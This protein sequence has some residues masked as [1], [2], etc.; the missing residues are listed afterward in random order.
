MITN[1]HT[2]T[3][4]L[5]VILPFLN[6][7]EEVYNTVCSI[8]KTSINV[9]IILINDASTDKYDYINVAKMFDCQ[10]IVHAKRK[11]VAASRDEGVLLCQTDYFLLLDAHMR[12]YQNNWVE[13]IVN[14]LSTNA[15]ILLCCQTKALSINK[16]GQIVLD[17]ERP[18]S[19]GSYIDL[20]NQTFLFEPKWIFSDSHLTYSSPNCIDIPCVLGAGYATSKQY[21]LYLK[22]LEELEQYGND[23][24]YI[25]IKVWLDGGRCVLLKN[26]TIGHI[27]RNSPPYPINQLYRIYNRLLLSELLLPVTLLKKVRSTLKYTYNSH[28]YAHAVWLISENK[29]IVELRKYYKKKFKHNFVYFESINNQH[30]S[31]VNQ[32]KNIDNLLKLIAYRIITQFHTVTDMGLIK[33]QIGLI[34]FLFHYAQYDSNQMIK[35]LALIHLDNLCEKIDGRLSTNFHSGLCGIGWGIEYLSQAGFIDEEIDDFLSEIDQ[36]VREINF[37]RINDFDQNF[38]LGGIVQYINARLVGKIKNS[39]DVFDSKLISQLKMK[40]RTIIS[41][42]I[43]ECDSF[44]IYINFLHKKQEISTVSLYDIVF[45][46]HKIE[47]YSLANINNVDLGLEGLA[48]LGLNLIL[49]SHHNSLLIK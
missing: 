45:I 29:R 8:R 40:I 3:V 27:Y 22:G 5:T 14:Q 31:F 36:K 48:G 13:I 24:S 26:V 47:E 41:R 19:Y 15:K 30:A 28:L 16:K 43:F 10:Y 23:E 38:G 11:G 37:D 34:I 1:T 35:D 2:G 20:Y 6:E 12:F 21:W 33:G 32:I 49:E 39:E 17:N 46:S 42:K 7:G 9:N 25:S 4:K 44:D 18:L